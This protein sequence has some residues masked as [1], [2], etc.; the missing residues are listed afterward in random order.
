MLELIQ[1]KKERKKIF[2]ADGDV[3]SFS[4]GGIILSYFC[5]MH[6]FGNDTVLL[7]NIL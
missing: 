7:I 2:D 5:K 3:L 1:K 4:Y 6:V